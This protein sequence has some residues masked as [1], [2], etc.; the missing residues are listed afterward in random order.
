MAGDGEW[1]IR[2]LPALFAVLFVP[3]VYALTRRLFGQRAAGFA[4]LLCAIHPLLLSYGQ[5]IRYYTFVAALAALSN[6]AFLGILRGR[7][8]RRDWIVHF[9]ATSGLLLS[10]YPAYAVLLAQNVV[11]AVALF[12][13]PRVPLRGWVISHA[14][15]LLVCVPLG[16]TALLQG[17]RDFGVAELSTGLLGH[18]LKIAYAGF[19]WS[20]G[21]YLFP[22]RVAALLG[23]AASVALL[24]MGL[25][26]R[27]G[28]TGRAPVWTAVTM[29]AVPLGVSLVL[30]AT[31]A[32]DSP[33]VNSAARTMSAFAPFIAICAYGAARLSARASTLIVAALLVAQTQSGIQHD[34]RL[35]ILNPIYT[36]PAREAAQFIARHAQPGDLVVTESDSLVERYLPPGVRARHFDVS[37]ANEVLGIL[38]RTPDAGVWFVQL[39]RDRTRNDATAAL[40]ARSSELRPLVN[41]TGLAEQDPTYRQVKERLLNRAAYAFRLTITQLGPRP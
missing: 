34:L 7:A 10:D 14:I 20:I 27:K 19:A 29:L 39:G 21:E 8:T 1:A 32:R 11:L 23:L 30:L 33:F 25:L 37:Q 24:A 4:V 9:L 26:S 41:T 35:D 22:W 5:I 6:A 3:A 38:E 18:I 31:V 12:R 16:A 40:V 2:L 28:P 13:Q 36:T 15:W 17:A